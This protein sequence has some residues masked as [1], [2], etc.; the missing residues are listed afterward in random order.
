MFGKKGF[1]PKCFVGHAEAARWAK[2]PGVSS[3]LTLLKEGVPI[4][5]PMPELSCFPKRAPS[6]FK[7]IDKL[8]ASGEWAQ[9]E[10]VLAIYNETRKG[11]AEELLEGPFTREELRARYGRGWVSAK[12][13]GL[14]QKDKVR[15]IDDYTAYGQNSTSAT[16]ETVDAGGIDC[17][18]G[19]I[20]VWKD[21][22]RGPYWQSYP[23]SC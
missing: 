19:V 3:L 21:A 2:F 13:F 18:L 12:R 8:L 23:G 20:K 7:S 10:D 9:A 11:L 6:A 14:V 16:E 17:V 22:L 5:G 15:P 4:F 1:R